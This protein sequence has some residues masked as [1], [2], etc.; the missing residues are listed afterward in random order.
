MKNNRTSPAGDASEHLPASVILSQVK[1]PAREIP[2]APPNFGREVVP[3]ILTVQGRGGS[4]SSIY[5]PGDEALRHS[6][7]NARSMRNECGIME[8]LEA[9]QRGTALLNWHLAPEDEN[10]RRQKKLVDDLTRILKRIPSFLEYRRNLLEALWY[11]RYAVSHRYAWM[12]VGG[13]NRV[14]IARWT[15]ING[16]K[17]VFRHDDGSGRAADGQIGIRVDAGH[18][19]GR[20]A[21]A[22][23]SAGN[24][25][26]EPTDLGSAYFLDHWERDLLVVHK[27]IIEDAGYEDSMGA[28]SIHG[29]GIR[30]RIYWSW[31]QMQECLSWMMEY[32]ERSSFG[33]EIWYY[34]M[35]NPQAEARTRAAA[36]ER[37][38]GGRSVV[39]MPRQFGEQAD[40]FDMERIEPGL[41]GIEHVRLMITD[42]FAS[43]IKRYILGQ[44]LTSESHS[45]G[46]GSRVADLHQETYKNII[47]YD[48][49]KLSETL[50]TDLIGPLQAFNFPGMRDVHVRF[51]IDTEAANVEKTLAAWKQAYEMGLSLKTQDVAGLIGASLPGETDDVLEKSQTK[52]KPDRTASSR[53]VAGQPYPQPQSPTRKRRR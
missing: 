47:R 34:P 52:N 39:L 53:G 11:G 27:H 16:D 30:N 20:P 35:G 5:R 26:I 18:G 19:S 10:D 31:F 3:H 21:N 12:R 51:V 33:I 37:I 6:L 45:T 15:P 1:D 22:R 38:G 23:S 17:L 2:A 40:Q 13:K 49:Q 42:F 4:P 24:G 9:R 48:A 29:V 25:K 44:V 7:D 36:E 46:L 50:T 43:K 8:C 14:G 32:L 28:D 41:G